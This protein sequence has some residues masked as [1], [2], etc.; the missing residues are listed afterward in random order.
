MKALT[1]LQYSMLKINYKKKYNI[2]TNKYYYDFLKQE[3]T[4][5]DLEQIFNVKIH[6]ISKS[7]IF[8]IDE[9]VFEFDK[10]LKYWDCWRNCEENTFYYPRNF[11]DF[12]SD[13]QRAGIRLKFRKL[14]EG[15]E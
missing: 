7:I 12:I 3:F 11:E 8:T 15:G 13:C 6:I 5:T 9:W 10:D 4:H 1:A 14:K 2:L